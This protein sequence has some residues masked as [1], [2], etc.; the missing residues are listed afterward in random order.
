MA[1]FFSSSRFA[2]LL[3][4]SLPRVSDWRI[5]FPLKILKIQTISIPFL[6]TLK[7][8]LL[9]NYCTSLFFLS[10]ADNF[11]SFLT[12]ASLT[13]A[14]C[15]SSEIANELISGRK[16]KKKKKVSLFYHLIFVFT[17]TLVRRE[18]CASGKV[19]CGGVCHWHSTNDTRLTF[20][21]FVSV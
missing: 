21:Y 6:F 4:S 17:F 7:I 11:F 12:V 10:I 14:F 19:K 1:S 8:D 18:R 16:V 20:F 9:E 13:A 2:V 3:L 5:I 15:C